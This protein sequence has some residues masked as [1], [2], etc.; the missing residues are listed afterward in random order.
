MT[1]EQRCKSL[2]REVPS[3]STIT[4]IEP[5]SLYRQC[6]KFDT[7]M[8]CSFP[9]DV[10]YSFEKKLWIDGKSKPAFNLP[11]KVPS[12][13]LETSYPGKELKCFFCNFFLALFPYSP[14]LH[15]TKFCWMCL[16]CTALY[17]AYRV[18]L[19]SLHLK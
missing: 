14:K 10:K 3:Y 2:Y 8:D 17:T 18:A 13:T 16:L 4:N 19:K 6:L 1:C 9:V 11:W 12:S 15:P 7:E 5:S